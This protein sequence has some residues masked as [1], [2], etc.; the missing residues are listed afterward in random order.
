[1]YRR[2]WHIC[3]RSPTGLRIYRPPPMKM[4]HC[5]ERMWVEVNGRVNYPLKECLISLEE[6]RDI[7]LD[8]PH[9]KF[10]IFWFTI[11]VSN[12][13]TTLAIPAWNEHPIPG[14]IFLSIVMQLF[15][16]VSN[17]RPST[18]C[19]KPTDVKKQPSYAHRQPTTTRAS[20]SCRTHGVTRVKSDLVQS[21]WKRSSC[22][23]RGPHQPKGYDFLCSL[24]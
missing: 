10:L 1:M 8:C 22:R 21:I 20:G 12:I 11:R 2:Y 9:Q 6:R 23:D 18:W 14:I 24:H 16:V 3:G 4:N 13:G 19:P 7:D 17:C 5:V 15:T